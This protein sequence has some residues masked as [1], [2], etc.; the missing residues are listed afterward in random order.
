MKQEI[1]VYDFERAFKDADRDYFSWDGYQALFDYYDEFDDFDLDVIAI[2]CD[3]SEY[4]EEEFIKTY[5]YI[6][7]FKEWS[8]ENDDD[9]EE[10]YLKSLVSQIDEKGYIIELENG[11]YLVWAF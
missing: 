3:V 8:E 7:T 1:N 5:D 10:E 6:Q 9:D 4:T 11:S 2:C